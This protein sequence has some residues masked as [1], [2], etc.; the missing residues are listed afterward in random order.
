MKYNT[1]VCRE[2]IELR[3]KGEDRK[4]LVEALD[5]ADIA[6]SKQFRKSGE[7]YIVHPIS[8]ARN[9]CYQYNDPELT[10]AGLLHDVIEDCPSISVNTIYQKFG[11]NVGFLV[12]SVTK[13]LISFK[14]FPEVVIED[15]IERLLWAGLKDIRVLLLKIADRQ[16]NIDTLKYLK[17]KK[18]VR[19][20]FETQAIFEPLKNILSYDKPL[21]IPATQK[22]LLNVLKRNNINTITEFKHFLLKKSFNNFNEELYNIVYKYSSNV[23]WRVNGMEMYKKLCSMRAYK[24][25]I[26]ILLVKSNGKWTIVDFKFKKGAVNSNKKLKMSIASFK[27]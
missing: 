6:H 5:F 21:S 17:T 11:F 25:K 9:L 12:E 7:K 24:D 27:T 26:D 13:D 10:A 1:S 4:L 3:Y 2:E 22:R 14:P 15:K 18:Q 19:M 20:A 16:D 8:T 23:I